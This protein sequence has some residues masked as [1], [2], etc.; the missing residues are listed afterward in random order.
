MKEKNKIETISKTTTDPAQEIIQKG[1]E[2][3]IIDTGNPYV[4]KITKMKFPSGEIISFSSFLQRMLPDHLTGEAQLHEIP[5]ADGL[6]ELIGC[7]EHSSQSSSFLELLHRKYPDKF[8]EG[9][10]ALEAKIKRQTTLNHLV[11]TYSSDEKWKEKFNCDEKYW[12]KRLNLSQ[13]ELNKLNRLFPGHKRIE[14]F[15]SPETID[16]VT[17]I[18]LRYAPPIGTKKEKFL[19]EENEK[20]VWEIK[21]YLR[22]PALQDK[23]KQ[24]IPHIG[25]S[26]KKVK[27]GVI[28][29]PIF[30]LK[31]VLST[32][33]AYNAGK[34][35]YD[36]KET[37]RKAKD[38]ISKDELREIVLSNKTIGPYDINPYMD[39]IEDIYR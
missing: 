19:G 25:E 16:N 11:K 15:Y 21:N 7:P 31:F 27:E 36:L 35:A 8:Q 23:Y 5:T 18:F 22:T 1:F 2:W 3:V 30:A 32:L 6:I 24:H 34:G 4:G 13:K 29:N 33:P 26:W 17:K 37:I 14:D 9:L 38:L 10:K 20:N 12:Y 39:L 28:K